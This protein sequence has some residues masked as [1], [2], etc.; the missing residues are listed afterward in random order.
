MRSNKLQ[1]APEACIEIQQEPLE[2]DYKK[3]APRDLQA[4]MAPLPDECTDEPADEVWLATSRTYACSYE[5]Y[6]INV[7]RTSGELIG[8][9][10]LRLVQA[11]ELNVRSTNVELYMFA[12]V[13]D[14]W[15]S[16]YPSSLQGSD[17]RG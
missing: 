4:K 7:Y 15:G 14:V 9:L 2:G 1:T 5:I 12:W 17:L 13:W 6:L 10:N 3:D 11:A 16:G 8:Q